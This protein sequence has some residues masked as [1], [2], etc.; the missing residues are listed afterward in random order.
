MTEADYEKALKL[1]AYV[2]LDLRKYLSDPAEYRAEYLEDTHC[3]I[4]EALTLL[5]VER[6]EDK[7]DEEDDDE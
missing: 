5:G 4:D 6:I 1:I 7:E 2:E 3:C